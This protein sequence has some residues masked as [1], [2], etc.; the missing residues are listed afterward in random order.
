[1]SLSQSALQGVLASATRNV[2]LQTLTITHPDITTLRL[3]NDRKNMWRAF[4][5]STTADDKTSNGNDGTLVNGPT[6]TSD[7]PNDAMQGSLDFDGSD[8]WVDTGADY[9]F[10]TSFTV[11]C[12]MY[13]EFESDNAD[14]PDIV[15][16]GRF[17][18][19][20]WSLWTRGGSEINFEL[21][22]NSNHRFRARYLSPPPEGTWLHIA[23]VWDANTEEARIY[24][25]GSLENTVN[26]SARSGAWDSTDTVK[27][28]KRT[29]DGSRW[30]DGKLSDVRVWYS[31]RTQTEIQNNMNTRLNGDESGL[32]GYWPMDDTTDKYVRSSF[33]VTAPAQ[34]PERP[35]Q[36]QITAGAVDQRVVEAVRKLAG[37]REQ[38]KINYEIVLASTPDTVEFGP[39]ELDF[40]SA[41][42][43]GLTSITIKASFLKGALNDM[44]PTPQF[45]PSNAA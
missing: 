18:D 9:A 37:K 43:D 14:D 13:Q 10:T 30:F 44:F 42:T 1:M 41:N 28:G 38:A 3:V 26:T 2:Y 40:D 45:A 33:E 6:W 15:G 24:I 39:V 17:R 21:N 8:D 23:G 20:N 35:P 34:N 29:V 12:W 31:V 16:K 11:E 22:D 19:N 27:F 25:N 32:V 5:T 7:G 4:Q 36:I